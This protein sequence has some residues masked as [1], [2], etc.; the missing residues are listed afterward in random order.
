MAT[1]V[2]LTFEPKATVAPVAG[3]ASDPPASTGAPTRAELVEMLAAQGVKA[4]AKATKAQLW[5]LLSAAQA[6]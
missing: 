4:P 1:I 2:G 3:V 5:E 6:G